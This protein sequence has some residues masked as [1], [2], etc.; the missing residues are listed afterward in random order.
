MLARPGA[1]PRVPPSVD[2]VLLAPF[3]SAGV[4][5]SGSLVEMLESTDIPLALG[6]LGVIPFV[7]PESSHALAK[8]IQKI[9]VPTTKARILPVL[10][11]AG[12]VGEGV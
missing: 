8:M 4:F 6:G 7:V 11:L 12:R 9:M 3:P 1:V 5:D 10:R 2:E